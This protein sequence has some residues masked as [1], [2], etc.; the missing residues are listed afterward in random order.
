MIF[1]IVGLGLMGGSFAKALKKYNIASQVYGYDHNISHQKEALELGFVDEI[2]DLDK[3]KES[4]V[5]ILAIPVDGII[6]FLKDF[7]ELKK[8]TTII[9]FGSTKELIVKNLPSHLK[10]NF[11]PAHP[12]TGTEFSGPQ[13]AIDELYEDKIIVLCDLEECGELHKSRAVDTFKTIGMKLIFMNSTVHDIHACYM[14]HLPHAI[15][16]SLANSVMDHEDP[17]DIISLAAGGFKDMS[18]VAKSSPNMWSDIFR[19][20]RTNLLESMDIYLKHFL[21][22]KELLEKEDYDK[23]NQKMKH[24]NG[25]HKIL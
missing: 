5:I 22:M 16:F 6:S 2:V 9:D 1:G 17:K 20:N 7:G 11:I 25:L 15:S 13:A 14:S 23:I 10:K 8:D 24:A 18:R 4:D 19:Q 21:E 3:L 12:M